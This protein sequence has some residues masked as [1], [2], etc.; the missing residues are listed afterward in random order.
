MEGWHDLESVKRM[1]YRKFGDRTVSALS[2]GASSLAGV[3][4]SD[5][6][7][8]ESVAV[9]HYA[10]RS[11]INVIDTAPWYGHGTSESI[12]GKALVGVPRRAYYLHTKCGRYLPGALDMFDFT[13]ERTLRSVDE[14]L[15]RLG[16]E[17]ID[18][19]QVHDPEFAPSLDIVLRETLPA[20]EEC[21]KQGKIRYIGAGRV[22]RRWRGGCRKRG[23]TRNIGVGVGA[24]S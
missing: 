3:F 9:V 10:V 19:M 16:V 22:G 20:L 13:Y 7:L 5:V 15:A 24:A 18:T 4:R 21:R 11:G 1:P 12:L 23:E 8:D 14:S 6:T 2:F 17:Y